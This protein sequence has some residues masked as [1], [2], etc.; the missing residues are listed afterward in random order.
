MFVGELEVPGIV[1]EQHF[2]EVPHGRVV[3]R[4]LGMCQL[5]LVGKPGLVVAHYFWLFY[6]LS[7]S[8]G[9]YFGLEELGQFELVGF[10]FVQLFGVL[11]LGLQAQQEQLAEQAELESS[12]HSEVFVSLE[13]LFHSFGWSQE[14][15]QAGPVQGIF[16]APQALKVLWLGGPLSAWLLVEEQLWFVFLV[17]VERR[18]HL[19][20]FAPFLEW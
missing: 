17:L 7:S 3:V 16:Q 8:L 9:L 1:E 4:Q 13:E 5:N 20:G 14:P 15:R 11:V 6:W 12:G 10:G 18:G 19:M 2:V